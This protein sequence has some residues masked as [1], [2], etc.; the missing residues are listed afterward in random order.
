[1]M[2]DR[3]VLVAQTLIHRWAL[4][5]LPILALIFRRRKRQLS[6]NWKISEIYIKVACKLKNLYC[7]VAKADHTIDFLL[8]A[9]RYKVAARSYLARAVNV[10]DLLKTI[11]IGKNGANTAATNSVNKDA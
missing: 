8:T 10:H 1:M 5:I 9:K 2:K 6:I 11:T 4:K 7:S 3:G